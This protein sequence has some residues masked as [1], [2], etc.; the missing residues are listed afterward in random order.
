MERH[1]YGSRISDGWMSGAW[2]LRTKLGSRLEQDGFLDEEGVEKDMV[3]LY[4][5]GG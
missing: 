1:G 3:F 2:A 4:E 5:F